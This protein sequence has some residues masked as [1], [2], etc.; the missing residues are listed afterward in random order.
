[1]TIYEILD[2]L[3]SNNCNYSNLNNSSDTTDYLNKK[4]IIKGVR[5]P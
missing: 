1:M 2:E 4:A 3:K 5:M